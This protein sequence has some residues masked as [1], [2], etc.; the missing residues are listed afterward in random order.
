M[1]PPRSHRARRTSPSRCRC[2]TC[3]SEGNG[4][5][6]DEPPRPFVIPAHAGIHGCDA[7]EGGHAPRPGTASMVP[8]VR[9]D[10]DQ[11]MDP[12]HRKRPPGCPDGP[13]FNLRGGSGA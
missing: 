12:E 3:C 11:V 6:G 10:D 2:A 5:G 13:F 9:R 1:L 7:L 4:G 8:R